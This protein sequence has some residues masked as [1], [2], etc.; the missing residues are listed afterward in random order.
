L[1]LFDVHWP[2][3]K[4]VRLIGVGVSNLEDTV[5][6]LEL[7]ETE[8]TTKSRKLQSTLDDLKQRFGDSSVKKGAD[9]KKRRKRY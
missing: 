5:R 8:Q 7:W 1:D 4:P 2:K 3:G 6:Q 9:I